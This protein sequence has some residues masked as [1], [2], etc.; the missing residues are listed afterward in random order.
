MRAQGD[1]ALAQG[2]A[3]I[4]NGQLSPEA[5]LYGGFAILFALQQLTV[6][7]DHPELLTERDAFQLTREA[8][9]DIERGL[10]TAEPQD[11]RHRRLAGPDGRGRRKRQPVQHPRPGGR[12]PVLRG[13]S[14]TS[15]PL[16]R[17]PPGRTRARQCRDGRVHR[18][19]AI[20]SPRARPPHPWPTRRSTSRIWARIRPPR[21]RPRRFLYKPPCTTL[22]PTP[23][24]STTCLSPRHCLPPSPSKCPITRA[25]R[26][27]RCSPTRMA[28][29]SAKGSSTAS[30]SS[31][32][33]AA[34]L[35]PVWNIACP[36]A[37]RRA[38]FSFEQGQDRNGRLF[39]A[40]ARTGDR[41]HRRLQ[42]HRADDGARWRPS[43]APGVVLAARNEAALVAG[44]GDDHGARAARPS[45]VVA[46]VGRARGRR[47]RRRRAR[48][49]RF[50][51]FDTWVNN[52][53]V[54]IY[55]RSPRSPTRTTAGSSRPTSG[56]WCTAP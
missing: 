24:H 42:R 26:S 25:T 12:D 54:S 3:D 28:K 14:R 22:C 23:R 31:A 2:I 11:R 32:R 48:S 36:A 5:S 52:A 18:D 53:G 34:P 40:F 56:A 47:A 41:H 50:G 43:G 35:L 38:C 7:N 46:D 17:C 1:L 13:D 20:R 45:H 6:V 29:G 10:A 51:G 37:F 19:R 8:I 30:N 39:E 49:R 9:H 21:H 4:P 15:G 55:G 44:A 27:R 16:R 33:R